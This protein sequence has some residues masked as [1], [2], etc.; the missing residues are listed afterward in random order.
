VVRHLRSAHLLLPILVS[1]FSGPVAERAAAQEVAPERIEE[2][3]CE[4]CTIHFEEMVSIGG[5]TG[6]DL[7]PGLPGDASLDSRGRLWLLYLGTPALVFAPDGELVDSVGRVGAGPGE[8]VRPVSVMPAADSM[9]IFDF[10]GMA[11]VFTLEG[12]AV[13][14]ARLL[15]V[16]P[17]DAIPIHWPDTV[18]V[19]GVSRTADGAGWPL[20]LVSFDPPTVG[21]L[22]SFGLGD[23]ALSPGQTYSLRKVLAARRGGGAWV[24]DRMQYRVGAWSRSGRAEQLLTRATP[25]FPE[26]SPGG[27]GGPEIRPRPRVVGIHE[28]VDGYLWVV[29]H[30][31]RPEWDEAWQEGLARSGMSEFPDGEWPVEIL[32]SPDRL[33]RTRIEVVD[34]GSLEVLASQEIE[35]FV[36]SV[37]PDGRLL[38]SGEGVLPELKILDV[39]LIRTGQGDGREG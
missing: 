25:W 10:S 7:L 19:N 6:P 3:S 14:Q 20:H 39:S 21:P 24:G 8:F 38:V 34:P 9:V 37:L 1:L 16:S 28:D 17:R 4:D 27:I 26:D 2:E 32:P 22:N 11:N 35:A 5:E 33:Y 30:V 23:G 18:L 13:R 29:I 31:A 15:S 12:V 36:T